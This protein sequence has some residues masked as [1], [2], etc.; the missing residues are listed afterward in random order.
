MFDIEESLRKCGKKYST[1][2]Y[3]KIPNQKEEF[4]EFLWEEIKFRVTDE[5]KRKKTVNKYIGYLKRE[6]E[7]ITNN[8]I[9]GEQFDFFC[10]KG[11]GA[12]IDTLYDFTKQFLSSEKTFND[13]RAVINLYKSFNDKHLQNISGVEATITI[14][15]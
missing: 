14:K 1:I 7:I 13:T 6:S 15:A 10:F 2:E 5:E 12:D 3:T 4:E 11:N 9:T 8:N